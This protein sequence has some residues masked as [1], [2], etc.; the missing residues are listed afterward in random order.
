MVS[1]QQVN[2][3]KVVILSKG[4]D[5]MKVLVLGGNGFIGSHVVD[6]LLKSG[7]KVRVF[8]RSPEKY[9][10][11]LN[12]VD[13]RLAAFE[14]IPALAEAL[15]G[16]DVVCHLI[17]TTVP[18][19]SNLDPI[20][21]VEGNLINTLRLL[22]LMVQK[23]VTRI[24]YLSSGGTVYGIP[25][26]IPIPETHPLKPVC[27]YGVV[28]VAIEN[29][30]HMFGL[31][32]GVKYCV[33]RASN[34]YGERQGHSGVQGVIGTFSAKMLAGEAI[35]I[36]GDGT[37]VRDF[38]HVSDLAN[39][40]VRACESSIETVIN[41][42]SGIGHSINEIISTL[43]KVSGTTAQVTYKNSRSYDVP[44]VVLD[45]S[46]ARI[47]FDWNP[48]VDIESGIGLNWKWFLDVVRAS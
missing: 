20:S 22:H 48:V 40:C 45:I 25:D 26:V 2:L 1:Y 47:G 12:S 16:I 46:K 42:G 35:E 31:L 5:A 32:H 29:Y 30:L 7:H 9:R 10:S 3:L 14:N 38:I 18:S 24:V 6:Q 41:V 36:W 17:S 8:D 21:D 11:P 19:T 27:S 4:Y 15:E 39:I 44:E 13:Y 23:G 37:V 28:K 34:P 43:E 33:L